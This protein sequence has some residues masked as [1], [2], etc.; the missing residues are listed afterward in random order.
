MCFYAFSLCLRARVCVCGHVRVHICL[1][2]SMAITDLWL[3]VS[4][5]TPLVLLHDKKCL[6]C[7]D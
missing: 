7:S 2:A 6:L 3:H 1:S 5:F 4:H